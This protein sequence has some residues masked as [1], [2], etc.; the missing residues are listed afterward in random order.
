MAFAVV[1]VMTIEGARWEELFLLFRNKQVIRNWVTDPIN[2]VHVQEL[3][4]FGTGTEAS[5]A[6]GGAAAW[7]A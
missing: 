6:P 2:Y 7:V 3:D 1:P 4:L 5:G